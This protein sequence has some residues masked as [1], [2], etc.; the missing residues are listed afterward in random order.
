M[1]TIPKTTFQYGTWS[2]LAGFAMFILLHLSGLNPLGR[3][4]WWGSW[5]PVLFICL[6]TRQA[7]EKVYAG[8]IS[9]WQAYRTG[10]LTAFFSALLFALLAYENAEQSISELTMATVAYNDFLLKV[11]GGVLVSF[12]TAAV[13]RK[14]PPQPTEP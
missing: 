5:I 7:R 4:S 8:F 13:F 6:A 2:G 14:Q 9:Y 12:V 10:F 3:A 11:L 1:Q